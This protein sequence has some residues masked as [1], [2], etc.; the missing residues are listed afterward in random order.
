M[1][2]SSLCVFRMRHRAAV[3]CETWDLCYLA[4]KPESLRGGSDLGCGKAQRASCHCG[5]SSVTLTV[6]NCS[7]RNAQNAEPST[8]KPETPCP[9]YHQP[10][11]QPQQL[12]NRH[13]VTYRTLVLPSFACWC[14]QDQVATVLET[15][16]MKVRTPPKLLHT[17][18]VSS[19]TVSSKQEPACGPSGYGHAD[20]LV[21]ASL[22]FDVCG[23]YMRAFS[24]VLSVAQSMLDVVLCIC[25]V[26]P[27]CQLH[28]LDFC[29]LLI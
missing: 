24:I 11:R 16:V 23:P 9:A 19:A 7:F 12:L 18:L 3:C 28:Y 8:T 2:Q 17:P 6:R 10:S 14:E 29:L 4:V 13:R 26:T 1:T 27:Q 5:T 20:I 21:F 15:C 25:I 22:A